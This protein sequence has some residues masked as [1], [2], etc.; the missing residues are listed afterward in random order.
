MRSQVSLQERGRETAGGCR[1]G[2]RVRV[3][4]ETGVMGPTT[5][6]PGNLRKLGEE[7]TFACAVSLQGEVLT[8]S[9]LLP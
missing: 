6:H 8:N 4:A 3:G 9:F 7:K 5:K 2:G 1:G